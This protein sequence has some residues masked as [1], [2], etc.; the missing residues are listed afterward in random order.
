MQRVALHKAAEIARLATPSCSR[1]VA[2]Q[3]KGLCRFTATNFLFTCGSSEGASAAATLGCDT[4]QRG[5]AGKPARKLNGHTGQT[6]Y[7]VFVQQLCTVVSAVSHRDRPQELCRK[8]NEGVHTVSAFLAAFSPYHEVFHDSP[9]ILGG[10]MRKC[11][12]SCT[13]ISHRFPIRTQCNVAS[14]AYL[15]RNGPPG[16]PQGR[17]YLL[18][19]TAPTTATMRAQRHRKRIASPEKSFS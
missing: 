3:R 19:P 2:M 12:G 15:A 11:T 18:K 6:N 14:H 5:C 13:N 8:H 1:K 10:G 4:Q 7:R 17:C 9:G 16:P